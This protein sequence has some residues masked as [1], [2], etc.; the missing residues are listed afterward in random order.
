MPPTLGEN[1]FNIGNTE[2]KIFVPQG[3]GEAYKRKW[4]PYE[5]KIHESSNI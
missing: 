3:C 1:V 4:R 2:L 5:G